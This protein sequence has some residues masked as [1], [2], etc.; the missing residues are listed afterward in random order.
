MIYK[1]I[2]TKKTWE[3]KQGNSKAKWLIVGTF[4]ENDDGKQFIELNMFPGVAFYVFE[5]KTKD[6]GQGSAQEPGMDF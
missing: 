4:K 5:Q 3:D 6:Q 2:C 1:N